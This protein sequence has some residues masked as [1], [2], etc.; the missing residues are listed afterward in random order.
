M[1]DARDRQF[2]VLLSIVTTRKSISL[3]AMPM[4]LMI[5][6][7]MTSLSAPE[8]NILQAAR[9]QMKE[10]DWNDGANDFIFSND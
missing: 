10:A 2:I 6:S 1:K 9:Q 7:L 5:N 8:S 4:S 3:V